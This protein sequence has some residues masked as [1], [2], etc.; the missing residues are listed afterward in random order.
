MDSCKKSGTHSHSHKP[1]KKLVWAFILTVSFAIVEMYNGIIGN[2]TVLVADAW[3][4]IT[5]SASMLIAL[6]VP[7]LLMKI[8][9]D[10]IKTEAVA[11][12]LCCLLLLLPCWEIIER[13]IDKWETQSML[14]ANRLISV[15]MLGLIVNSICMF[16]LHGKDNRSHNHNHLSVDGVKLHIIGDLLGSIAAII[17]GVISILSAKA[18]AWADIIGSSVIV[19]IL[20]IGIAR[21]GSTS[22][23][24]IFRN[25][26][27]T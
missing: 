18:S 10:R 11:A 9:L 6:T 27:A 17:A 13:V 4:M 24:A 22:L 23:R 19:I 1:T 26:P 2:A 14:D 20:L 5:D 15:A 3:H 12:L 8:W 21:L 16:L 25:E 7:W